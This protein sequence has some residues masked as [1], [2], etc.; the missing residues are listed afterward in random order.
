MRNN[1]INHEILSNL[2]TIRINSDNI[3]PNPVI[4]N[5][6]NLNENV[7]IALTDEEF[8]KIEIV[9]FKDINPESKCNICLDCFKSS[10]KILKLKC[11]HIFDFECIQNWLK[12]H[13]NK[14]PIC[15]KE[16]AKGHPI[17]L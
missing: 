8:N 11:G 16:V 5:E 17:N 7:I 9:E 2:S 6:N 13:S 4:F 3:F 12:N 10:S 15:R 14:C 1:N